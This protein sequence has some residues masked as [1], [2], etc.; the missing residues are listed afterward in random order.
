MSSL[1]VDNT[2]AAHCQAYVAGNERPSIV[3]TTVLD[4]SIHTRQSGSR[5]W[6]SLIEAYDSTNATH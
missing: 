6:M 1:E 2:E 3:W 4:L 5:H